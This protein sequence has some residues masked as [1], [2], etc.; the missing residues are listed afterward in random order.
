MWDPQRL[1]TLWTFMACYRDSFTFTFLLLA[2]WNWLSAGFNTNITPVSKD[3]LIFCQ[4][5]TG[6]D[7]PASTAYNYSTVLNDCENYFVFIRV[8]P[9]EHESQQ[10]LFHL[11]DWGRKKSQ[12]TGRS[13]GCVLELYSG[14]SWIEFRR[15]LQL[16]SFTEDFVAFC[17]SSKQCQDSTSI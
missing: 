4:S 9:K 17:S 5:W 13:R 7:Y 15:G 11:E 1:T 16:S 10:I 2:H 8:V 14:D 3:V 12:Q 6:S